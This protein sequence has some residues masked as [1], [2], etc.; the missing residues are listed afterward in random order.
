MSINVIK[1]IQKFKN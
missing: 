1:L